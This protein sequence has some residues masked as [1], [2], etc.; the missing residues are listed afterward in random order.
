V[1]FSRSLR[2]M[3][4]KNDAKIQKIDAKVQ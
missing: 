3:K 4:K 2:L 1:V